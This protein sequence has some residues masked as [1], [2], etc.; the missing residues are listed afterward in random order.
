MKD[1]IRHAY[2]DESLLVLLPVEAEYEAL[3]TGIQQPEIHQL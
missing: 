3:L 1:K 2:L